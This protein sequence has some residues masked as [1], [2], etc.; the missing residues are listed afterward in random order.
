[1]PGPCKNLA[2]GAHPRSR[3]EN[4]P[5]ARAPLDSA[6]S[7]PLTRGKRDVVDSNSEPLGLIPAHAGKTTHYQVDNAQTRAHPRSRGENQFIDSCLKHSLGSS[8]LTRGKRKLIPALS[9]PGGLIP[10]HAGKTEM[11]SNHPQP[12][13]AHPRSRGENC[14]RLDRTEASGGSSPLTR[15]KPAIVGWSEV[16]EGL[17]PAHAGKTKRSTTLTRACAAHPRSRGENRRRTEAWRSTVG[18]SPLTRGKL[19]AAVFHEGRPRLIPAHAGKTCV[20]STCACGER[21]HPRSR[22][23]NPLHDPLGSLHQGLIPAHAGKT[24]RSGQHRMRCRAHPRSRG[25]NST[26]PGRRLAETGSS[27]LTRGKL[28]I[29]QTEGHTTGL[30]PAHAGKTA[31]AP[32]SP[33]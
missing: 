32:T 13:R 19:L 27:P 30:I 10:A 24:M 2:S 15:G 31:H 9:K 20:A 16:V 12:C 14:A 33:T 29:L 17:I 23:E 11:S 18:S 4:L 1:M 28:D 21:A 5:G 6:G 26:T 25:E 22:G 7:S 3:G 8:P